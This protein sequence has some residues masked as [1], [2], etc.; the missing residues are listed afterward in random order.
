MDSR[1]QQQRL[2]VLLTLLAIAIVPLASVSAREAI[3]PTQGVSQTITAE[4][5]VAGTYLGSVTIDEPVPLGALELVFNLND[6]NGAL[7][8]EVVANRTQVFL[9]G[10]TITGNLTAGPNG[11]ATFQLESERF[12]SQISGRTVERQ[13]TLIGTVEGDGNLLS[14]EYTEI[15]ENFKPAPML[16]KGAFRVVRPFGSTDVLPLPGNPVTPTATP[17]AIDPNNPPTSTPTATPTVTRVPGSGEPENSV[18]F[19]PIIMQ[20]GGGLRSANNGVIVAATPAAPML[21]PTPTAT[22]TF[23]PTAPGNGNTRRLYLPA[24]SR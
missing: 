24:I 11:A 13:F 22:P 3:V 9:G 16:V 7:S 10:P 5:G 8:G 21:T 1:K 17:T 23:I 12:V 4:T 18:L 2:L 19:L 6:N 15:I 14:G 20:N